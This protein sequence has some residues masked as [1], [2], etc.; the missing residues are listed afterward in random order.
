MP[1]HGLL[2]ER[3]LLLTIMAQLHAF[4]GQLPEDRTQLYTEAVQL[5]L[6]RWAN[7]T[8]AGAGIV[9]HLAIPTLKMSDLR[10]GLYA[11]AF[12]AHSRHSGDGDTADIAE[13]ELRAW[14]APFLNND[15]NKAGVFIDY[16]RERAGLLIRHKTEAYTFPH[17]TFQ[18]FLAA[19]HLASLPDYA[20][21]AARLVR[22]E[23]DRW[24]EVF[25]L[26]AGYSTRINLLGQALNAVNA[27]C[28]FEPDASRSAAPGR[29]IWRCRNT[30]R[31]PPRPAPAR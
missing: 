10:A 26:A 11:V 3:P 9:E 30:T 23:P 29:S 2:A 19:C 25:L 6:E 22:A 5:L 1:A 28:P 18:E 20:S 31:P 17:R 12:K 4:T 21:E 27:L 14:L 13:G 8:G 15:W 16:I 24:R 7:P